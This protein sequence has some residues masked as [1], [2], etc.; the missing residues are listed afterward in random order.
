MKRLALVTGILALAAPL[1]LAQTTTWKSDPAHSEVDFTIL[2]LSVSHVHGRFGHVDATI[3]LNPADI[4][5][6]TVTATIDIT[7]VSTGEPARDN[8]LKTPDF[9]GV[10]TMPSAT[11][12]STSVSKNADGTLS[13]AGNL[14]LHGVTKPEACWLRGLYH[15]QPHRLW[16]RCQVPCG[17]SWR[18]RQDHHRARRSAAVSS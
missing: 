10:D 18:R 13:V 15:H 8:H 4:T 11:F 6:S 2:H 7:G 17:G 3:A 16:H 14:T 5:K 12:T 1:A 9:F